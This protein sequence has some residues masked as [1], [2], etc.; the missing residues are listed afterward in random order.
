MKIFLTFDYELFFG[1]KSGSLEKSIIEPT[2]EL[3]NILDRYGAKATFFVDSGY[4]IKLKEYSQ[5]N[6]NLRFD[7]QVVSEQIR[8]LSESGHSVQL[9][10]HPHWEDAKYEGGKW[11]FDTSRFS[12]NSFSKEEVSAIV[13]RYK[14]AIED[15]TLTTVFAF[16]AGGWCIQPFSHVAN[17]LKEN[18]IWLDSTVFSGGF[19]NSG[20]HCFDFRKTPGKD[21]WS[22]QEDIL[23]E[24]PTGDFTEL[25]ISS[26]RISP[27]FY[28]MFV[29]VKLFKLRKHEYIGDGHPVGAGKKDIIKMLIKFSYGVVSVDGFKIN[30][31][32]KAFKLHVKNSVKY[33]VTIG[34]PKAFSIYSLNKLNEFILE[35]SPSH[36][37]VSMAEKKLLSEFD[38]N[39]E[40]A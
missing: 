23:K 21:V 3:I 19:Y 9:H 28:W 25:P 12:L 20:T 7:L 34:H 13:G 1:E 37:F 8:M 5:K 14:K 29:L 6:K 24:E 40:R 22:F 4:L 39:N 31:L 33:F 26:Y 10:I 16:R 36:E 32:K 35:L 38:R 30:Y 18:G 2:N 27:F 15:I 11:V 17:A